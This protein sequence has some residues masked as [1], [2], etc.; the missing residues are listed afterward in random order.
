MKFAARPLCLSAVVAAISLASAAHAAVLSFST[1]APAVGPND[2]SNLV[3]TSTADANVNPSG[4]GY[5]YVAHDNVVQGQSFLTGSNPA[6]Y[7]IESVTLQHVLYNTPDVTYYD[8]SEANGLFNIRITHPTSATAL[9]VI[10]TETAATV[11]GDP[12]NIGVA[13]PGQG[14]GYFV[15]FGLATHPILLPNTV[16]GFDVGG[17]NTTFFETNGTNAN[18]YAGGTA[19]ISGNADLAPG[20]GDLTLTAGTGDHVFIVKLTPVAVP[21]PASLAL[22][23][24]GALA[25][26]SSRK[27]RGTIC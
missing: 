27:R 9:Q 5:S 7:R 22:L 18:P 12:N 26:L 14:T 25:L 13:L 23:A 21:E 16:Y 11:P 15:T 4:G 10:D 1:N 24:S 17:A 2:I 6:G 3:G 19:Y 20:V 8:T